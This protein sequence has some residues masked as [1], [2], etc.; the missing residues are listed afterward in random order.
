M[1]IGVD[2]LVQLLLFQLNFREKRKLG[3]SRTVIQLEK[4][5]EALHVENEAEIF[6]S[7][8]TAFVYIYK[9]TNNTAINAT[10]S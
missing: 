3:D 6:G 10:V 2:F 8:I 9:N 4:T 5:E 1:G 7:T